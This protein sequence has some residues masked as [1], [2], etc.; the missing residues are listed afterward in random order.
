M[1]LLI[2]IIFSFNISQR[3][4]KY[5][6]VLTCCFATF[7][8]FSK[9]MLNNLSFNYMLLCLFVCVAVLNCHEFYHNYFAELESR[10]LRVI[11][12]VVAAEDMPG[13][14]ENSMFY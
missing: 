13:N 2:I 4:L 8:Y 6:C 10:A 1:A 7:S 3:C 12:C 9:I 14:N 5:S 11:F